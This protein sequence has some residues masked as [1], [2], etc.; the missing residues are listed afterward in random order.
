MHLCGTLAAEE[1]KISIGLYSM[2]PSAILEDVN[3][4][5]QVAIYL[6]ILLK[7]PRELG[8]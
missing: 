8:I 4:M 2:G 6:E 5:V 3:I 1:N 7:V